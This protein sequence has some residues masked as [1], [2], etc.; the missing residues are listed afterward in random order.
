MDC[1]PSSHHTFTILMVNHVE[2]CEVLALL[3]TKSNFSWLLK[4]YQVV[5]YMEKHESQRTIYYSGVLGIEVDFELNLP[6]RDSDFYVSIKSDYSL[7]LRKPSSQKLRG[8]L[9][10][11][12]ERRSS[13]A[14]PHDLIDEELSQL[15]RDNHLQSRLRG[16]EENHE[17][18]VKNIGVLLDRMK[19]LMRLL[20]AASMVWP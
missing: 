18:P 7:E 12:L 11:R 14:V 1:E 15:E 3:H 8:H 2:I 5:R 9:T 6:C 10:V 17:D 4:A 16:I 20:G 19:P 13:D